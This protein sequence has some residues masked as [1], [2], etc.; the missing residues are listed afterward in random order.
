M[1]KSLRAQLLLWVILFVS[2]ILLIGGAMQYQQRRAK[3]IEELKGESKM[4][5]NALRLFFR[6]QS[7]PL[8]MLRSQDPF[9]QRWKTGIFARYL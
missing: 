4:P 2:A 9:R 1:F 7:M 3:A 6:P 5:Q 8:K